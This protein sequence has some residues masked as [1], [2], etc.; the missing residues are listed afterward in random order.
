MEN[1]NLQPYI[2]WATRVGVGLLAATALHYTI[3]FAG[4]LATGIWERQHGSTVV[5][6]DS[7]LW[8]SLW[9]SLL[10]AV[11]WRENRVSSTGP[12]PSPCGSASGFWGLQQQVG[13][14]IAPS[15][16]KSPRSLK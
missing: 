12:S 5:Y 11:I 7:P 6:G 1:E 4:S 3:Y 9:L 14:P 8:I 10:L 16:P 2:A 15:K 13:I